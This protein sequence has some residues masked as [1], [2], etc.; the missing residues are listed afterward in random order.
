MKRRIFLE[1]ASCIFSLI[2]SL[3]QSTKKQVKKATF[4][5]EQFEIFFI[6]LAIL[7]H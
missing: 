4:K 6:L 3:V 5:G 1:L 7:K 2:N